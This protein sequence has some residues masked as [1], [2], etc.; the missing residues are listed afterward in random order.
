MFQAA[1]CMAKRKIMKPQAI[2]FDLDGT[3]ADTALDLGG[4]LNDILRQHKLPEK[5]LQQIRPYAAHGSAALIGFGTGITPDMPEFAA[6]QRDYLNH[7][8]QRFA[9]DTVLFDGVNAV[10]LHL[11]EQG[12]KWGIVTNKHARFTD[13]LVPQLHFAVAPDVVVSGD[14]CP[15]AKPHPQSLFYACQQIQVQPEYCWYVGD[16][17]RDIQAGQR[18]GMKTILAKWGYI[19]EQD[20]PETW[21]ADFQAAQM[22]DILRI[23]SHD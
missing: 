21:G 20:Q 5:T 1:F 8:A 23:L 4:T 19:S 16:A 15:Q 13:K 6:W 17:E 7:Y 11:K 3:L 9:K 18:A 10:L 22:Q 2:L 12:I 14:T